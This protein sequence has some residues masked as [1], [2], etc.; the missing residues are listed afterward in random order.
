MMG[1]TRNFLRFLKRSGTGIPYFPLLLATRFFLF[2]RFLPSFCEGDKRDLTFL[3][4]GTTFCE[5]DKV[6][7]GTL[8]NVKC[9]MFDI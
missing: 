5:G 7:G 3:P 8:G 9:E 1:S 6:P 2:A 4:K